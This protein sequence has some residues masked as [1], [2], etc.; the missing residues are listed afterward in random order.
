MLGP[1]R[2]RDQQEPGEPEQRRVMADQEPGEEQVKP[3]QGSDDA[4]GKRHDSMPC[5]FDVFLPVALIE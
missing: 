1:A 2:E 4:P 3:E 5:W